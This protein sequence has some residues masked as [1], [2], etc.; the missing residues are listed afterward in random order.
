MAR[1]KIT[2]FL[3]SLGF[4]GT[5]EF[6]EWDVM[7]PDTGATQNRWD[8][9]GFVPVS[10]DD[11]WADIMNVGGGQPTY[12]FINERIWDPSQTEGLAAEGYGKIP[13]VLFGPEARQ[14]MET[15]P[16]PGVR[17]G[18][19]RPPATAGA[20]VSMP[21][22]EA[23]SAGGVRVV[24]PARPVGGPALPKPN[25]ALPKP[26]TAAL[27]KPSTAAL[28]KPTT[29]GGIP[30]VRGPN[31]TAA[32][33]PE[34][35]GRSNVNTPFNR[36]RPLG[37]FGKL[38]RSLPVGHL[39]LLSVGT[40]AIEQS[41]GGNPDW[42]TAIAATVAG[43]GAAGNPYLLGAGTLFHST[44]LGGPGEEIVW[45]EDGETYYLTKDSN[46]E[47]VYRPEEFSPVLEGFGYR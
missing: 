40:A 27:P 26:P 15:M 24:N 14:P 18:M 29:I 39:P 44:D 25:A 41:Q 1:N 7:N 21:V 19:M 16:V 47:W 20:R 45:G 34:V 4:G 43:Y 6:D 8:Y 9:R 36:T 11:P 13:D 22:P 38:L 42:L 12:E 5:D 32:S 10:E 35:A 31:A 3:D 37:L 30:I 17:T 2:K 46:G 28:P 23:P 33:M